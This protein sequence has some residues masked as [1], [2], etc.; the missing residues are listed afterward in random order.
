MYHSLLSLFYKNKN[1]E[2]LFNSS[3]EMH[4]EL[5][6]FL[7]TQNRPVIENTKFIK[8]S[9][10]SVESALLKT[11]LF[12]AQKFKQNIHFFYCST[13]NI[14]THPHSLIRSPSSH[15]EYCIKIFYFP[16]TNIF[17][18]KKEFVKKIKKNTQ[19]QNKKKSLRKKSSQKKASLKH[20]QKK[21][22]SL[23]KKS[24]R[25]KTTFKH[26]QKKKKRFLK[27]IINHRAHLKKTKQKKNHNIII[28]NEKLKTL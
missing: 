16:K 18:S 11:F 22:K 21:K 10:T 24:S 26:R 28:H 27:Q 19:Y 6:N 12:F 15:T 2:A 5:N 8:S 9:A 17:Y 14:P 20:R 7:K 13:L 1:A 3:E 4:I 23:H 25:K